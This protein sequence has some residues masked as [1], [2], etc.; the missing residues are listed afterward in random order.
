MIELFRKIVIFLIFI[1]LTTIIFSQS[2]EVPSYK[3][4]RT[5]VPIIIDGKI[6]DAAWAKACLIDNFVI[7]SDGTPS[8]YKTEA[9]ILYDD[10]FIY[11]AFRS[12]DDNIWS[13]KSRRDDH[14]WE[15]E[16]VEVFIRANPNESSYIEIEVNPLGAI[17]DAY[18][19]DSIKGLPYD[20]WNMTDLKWAVDVQGT[21]DNKPGD[22]AWTCEFAFPM[23]N[24]VTAPAI[25]PKAGD[26]WYIN[27]YRAELKPEYALISWS[28]T[29][30][31]NFHMPGF[32]GKLIFSDT[33]VP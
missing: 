5:S 25:P 15:E 20:S 1:Y 19:L 27:L 31:D 28:P 21:I 26:I 11:F 8:P 7:N 33:K 29:Y 14:L 32:F 6:G 12:F 10:E 18:M 3:A 13:T 24:A 30:K 9:K 23:I 22:T 4:Y 17:F 2:K 16:V